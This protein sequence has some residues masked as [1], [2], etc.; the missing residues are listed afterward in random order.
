MMW[1]VSTFLNKIMDGWCTL[2]KTILIIYIWQ[3]NYEYIIIGTHTIVT[4]THVM[5]SNSLF[6]FQTTARISKN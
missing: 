4:L 6:K 3:W 2:F 5:L 1:M